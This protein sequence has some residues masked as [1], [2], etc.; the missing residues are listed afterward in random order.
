[1]A[2]LFYEFE[3]LL[4]RSE[5]DAALAK[6]A[7]RDDFGLEFVVIFVVISE[8]QTFTDADFASGAHQAFPFVGFGL[9]LPGEEDF[10]SSVEKIPGRRIARAHCL[11]SQPAAASVEARGKDAGVVED[12]QIGWPQEFGEITELEIVELARQ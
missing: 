3:K 2:D 6:I 4:Y 11:R 10:Y 9:Q 5:A 12:D 7:A 8:E 1:M